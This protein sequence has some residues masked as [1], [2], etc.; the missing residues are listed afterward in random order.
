VLA[1]RGRGGVPSTD[2]SAVSLNVTVTEPQRDGW[3]TVYP[4]GQ[5]R[6]LA[7]SLNFARSATVA[8]AVLSGIGANGSVCIVSSADAHVV[9]DVMGSW[10]SSGDP[11][12]FL[13]PERSVD[14][15]AAWGTGGPVRLRAGQARVLRPTGSL[16]VP[17]SARVMVLNATA[18]GAAGPGFVALYPCDGP[19]PLASVLNVVAKQ[20]RANASTVVVAQDGTLCAFASTDVDLIVDVAGF[21]D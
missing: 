1:V 16:G 10:G 12:S 20:A 15:R 21:A 11:V 2:V 9:V 14:T 18:V 8:N 5:P 19:R 4:C 13:R 17:A 7:S 6:P 3:L